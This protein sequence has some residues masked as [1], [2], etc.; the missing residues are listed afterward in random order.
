TLRLY[1]STSLLTGDFLLVDWFM[2]TRGNV[3]IAD[4]SPAREDIE[5]DIQQA[6][7][8]A[9]DASNAYADAQAEFERIQAE[10]YADGI[11]DAEEARAI[12]DAKD[13]R[14]EAKLYAEQQDAILEGVLESYTDA[15]VLQ[16]KQDAIDASNAYADAQAEIERIQAEAYADGIVDAE[17][18]RAIQDAK[19]R[20]DEAKL[21]A[22]QQDVILEG[23][24]EN[25]T[26][27]EISKIEVGGANLIRWSNFNIPYSSNLGW[28]SIAGQHT[29]EDSIYKKTITTTSTTARAEWR[30]NNLN[31]YIDRNGT[32]SVSLW[33]KATKDLTLMGLVG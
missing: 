32:Y 16:A 13:R 18:A 7:Q 19:D 11:V 24:L 14:D 21:Y 27:D 30:N 10:A 12:Q 9:I 22:E 31:N 25:Y 2:L 23:V 3:S 29:V 4:W 26:D 15:E 8:N 5:Q 20:R 33:Y 28:R 1:F 6:R 17:E